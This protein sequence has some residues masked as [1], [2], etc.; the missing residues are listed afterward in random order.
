[1]VLRNI[2][3]AELARPRYQVVKAQVI[4]L[5]QSLKPGDRLPS[6]RRLVTDAGVSHNTV[7]KAMQELERDGYVD[8]EVGRGAFVS[9]R[10]QPVEG[11]PQ[12]PGGTIVYAAPEWHGHVVWSLGNEIALAAMRSG[13]RML[14]WRFFPGTTLDALTSF[15]PSVPDLVGV[16]V[17]P[18]AFGFSPAHWQRLKASGTPVVSLTPA[19]P[20]SSVATVCADPQATGRQLA[21]HLLDLGHR[22]LAFL[23]T[24]PASAITTAMIAGA[25]A[26]V[27][28]A[29]LP[30]EAFTAHESG[31]PDFSDPLEAGARLAI[32]AA[33]RPSGLL[34]TSGTSAIAAI[35][36]LHEAGLRV[37]TDLSVIGVNDEPLFAQ[38]V[39]S[40]SV[41]SVD[42]SLIASQALAALSAPP[43][44]DPTIPIR[45]IA[46]ES[47][48]A[49]P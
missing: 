43:G 28:A 45:I 14:P 10:P 31:Q 5:I 33:T 41:S 35:R 16:V 26:A 3:H 25:A 34:C 6:V 19:L 15:L 23:Q 38:L 46:R 47:T 30:G 49:P 32:A 13:R 29:G 21:Q 11:C 18:V 2:K 44:P 40:L 24:Q 36:A 22:R 27:A 48:A 4:A 9:R 17:L 1:M 37:P 20:G 39:P 12:H 7:V 42:Y 8:L